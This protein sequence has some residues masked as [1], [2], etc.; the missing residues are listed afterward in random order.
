MKI[1]FPIRHVVDCI[2]SMENVNRK[3]TIVNHGDNGNFINE[4]T[5]V[6]RAENFIK[7]DGVLGQPIHF[8]R[9][10]VYNKLQNRL[11]FVPYNDMLTYP[12]ETFKRIYD[13]LKIEY[14]KHDFENIKQTVF[15][16]DM[17]HGF[18]PNSLHRIKEGKLELPRQRDYLIFNEE[19]I[20]EIEEKRYKDITD[21]INQISWVKK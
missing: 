12:E 18:A 9:D 19:Y 10:I 8:L 16:Q 21:Y 7:E 2:I 13:G 11:I 1:L 5:T 4:Q 17:H 3:S 15:E 6:G 20:K 14:F